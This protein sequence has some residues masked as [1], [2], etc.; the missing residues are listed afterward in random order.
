MW[1][2]KLKLAILAL[3]AGLGLGYAVAQTT[4]VQTTLSGNEVFRAAQ[5][6]GG[7]EAW[8][9]L[10]TVR[11]SMQITITS[12]SGAATSTGVGGMLVWTSTAPTTWTVTFPA[13]PANGTF[14]CLTTDTTLTTLVTT[15]AGGSD[16]IKGGLSSSTLTAN[17]TVACWQYYSTNTTWYR[18]Q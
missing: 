7:P 1:V 18:S 6:P 15:A 14:Q 8:L 5:G 12:G 17:A 16:T 4:T 2:S 3:I 13:A 10:R 9:Y 11:N